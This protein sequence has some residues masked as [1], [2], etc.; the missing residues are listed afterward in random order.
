MQSQ[1]QH[2]RY[3]QQLQS[4]QQQQPSIVPYNNG[5]STT[6]IS[7]DVLMNGSIVDP[8][9]YMNHTAQSPSPTMIMNTM[10]Q[11]QPQQST[12]IPSWYSAY[13]NNRNND[14]IKNL[15]TSVVV[16]TSSQELTKFDTKACEALFTEELR[17][18]FDDFKRMTL[19]DDYE[20]LDNLFSYSNQFNN[21]K[22]AASMIIS[23]YRNKYKDLFERYPSLSSYLLF[24][25][26]IIIENSYEGFLKIFKGLKTENRLAIKAQITR[27]SKFSLIY[28]KRKLETTSTA[29]DATSNNNNDDGGA[30]PSK[31]DKVAKREHPFFSTNFYV[32]YNI[33][34][35]IGEISKHLLPSE[36]AIFT[37]RLKKTQIKTYGQNQ[38]M[39]PGIISNFNVPILFTITKRINKGNEY[40]NMEHSDRLNDY[41]KLAF[42]KDMYALNC[43][44]LKNQKLVQLVTPFKVE[45]ETMTKSLLTNNEHKYIML[46][47]LQFWS[48]VKL[49]D[50]VT[51]RGFSE[52]VY[53]MASSTFKD[54]TETAPAESQSPDDDEALFTELLKYYE[55]YNPE[56]LETL[57]NVEKTND[58]ADVL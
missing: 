53:Y 4:Q 20:I 39:V 7:N 16:D 42:D 33:L 9:K 50:T 13:S 35:N 28:R 24:V 17:M 19:V 49:T 22:I 26:I 56:Y 11:A 14:H 21:S 51:N 18:D 38:R 32:K 3:Q 27:T 43:S 15:E 58:D 29:D 6:N 1:V 31:I 44:I 45:A 41:F 52:T 57:L 40:Y 2:P 10:Q 55:K 8:S 34:F 48:N 25:V 46:D 37:I 36:F 23:L 12:I 54:Y 5:T 30:G 47:N